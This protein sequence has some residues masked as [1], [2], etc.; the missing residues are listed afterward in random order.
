[1]RQRRKT[2]SLPLPPK[3]RTRCL[4]ACS[5]AST[6]V[7]TTPSRS[8]CPARILPSRSRPS[9]KRISP[10]RSLYEKAARCPRVSL[11]RF[12]LAFKLTEKRG[13]GQVRQA[14]ACPEVQHADH[15][16]RA[17]FDGLRSDRF[18]KDCEF[19]FVCYGH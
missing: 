5:G 10:R 16:R 13:P 11:S 2:T 8:K 14:D 1:M 17:R 3:T 4:K 15:Q 6:S 7:S 12:I 19:G 18:R 9:K